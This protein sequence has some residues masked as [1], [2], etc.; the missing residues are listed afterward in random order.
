MGF[1]VRVTDLNQVTEVDKSVSAIMFQ[2]PDTDGTIRDHQELVNKAHS[3]G[4][5]YF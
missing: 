3:A 4:V 1:D 2:Y 5:S